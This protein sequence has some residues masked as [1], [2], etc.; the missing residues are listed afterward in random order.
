MSR[1]WLWILL[2]IVAGSV[3]T[4]GIFTSGVMA[5]YFVGHSSIGARLPFVPEQALEQ[6]PIV[7]ERSEYESTPPE[8]VDELFEPFWEAWDI[9]HE[10]FVDQPID[11]EIMMRG[12]IEGA[13]NALGDQHTTYMDPS[14]YEQAN[15]PL[16]GSSEGIGAWV[17]T[18]AA[19][20]TIVSPMP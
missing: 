15:I 13:L 19:Y 6:L 2:G 1:K 18:N 3:I 12:A 17:D 20:L 14:T 11:D 10:E 16:Q 5:G 8:D 9:V 4:A 7:S